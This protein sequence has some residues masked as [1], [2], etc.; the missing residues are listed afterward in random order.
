MNGQPTAAQKRFHQ[1]CR[2][3]GC[4]IDNQPALIHHIKGARMRLKGVDGFAGEW[5]VLGLCDGHHSAQSDGVSVHKNK[6]DF[7]SRWS[8]E[9][10]L[11]TDLMSEYLDQFGEYPMS[12]DEYLTI[13]ERA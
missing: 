8:T 3:F 4:L 13:L 6:R 7:E 10:E 11:W 1:W 12:E 2:D 5:Y 9:K